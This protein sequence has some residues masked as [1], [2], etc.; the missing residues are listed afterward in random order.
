MRP[1]SI[2]SDIL[3]SDDAHQL[4]LVMFNT[5]RMDFEKRNLALLDMAEELF[6]LAFELQAASA[7]DAAERL[8]RMIAVARLASERFERAA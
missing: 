3:S 7:D 6:S 4:A 5:F 8:Q 1:A 2:H